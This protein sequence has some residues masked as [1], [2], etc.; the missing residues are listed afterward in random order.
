MSSRGAGTLLSM[1]VRQLNERPFQ[2]HCNFSVKNVN[3]HLF[4]L[5]TTSLK[6]HA[7]YQRARST[8]PVRPRCSH[9]PSVDLP[10]LDSHFG[11]QTFSVCFTSLIVISVVVQ[12]A[13]LLRYCQVPPTC[14]PPFFNHVCCVKRDL[15]W[16]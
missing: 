9:T 14:S 4:I 13:Q 15:N 12:S 2:P 16:D 3:S 1:T 8:S 6:D 5:I 7:T 11:M 10:K